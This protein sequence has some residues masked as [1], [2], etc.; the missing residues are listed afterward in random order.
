MGGPQ[1]FMNTLTDLAIEAA[2]DYT[3]T[4]QEA[5]QAVSSGHGVAFS[6]SGGAGHP[7]SEGHYFVAQGYDPSTGLFDF[8]ETA[9]P[10]PNDPNAQHA[11]R[12]GSR[13][14]TYEQVVAMAGPV[15]ALITL[16]GGVP[17]VAGR[18]SDAIAGVGQDAQAAAPLVSDLGT[19]AG[20][21]STTVQRQFDLMATGAQSTVEEMGDTI[22]T[23]VTDINGDTVQTFTDLHGNVLNQVA[24][25][26]DGT[27]I[28][29]SDMGTS[30]SSIVD[31]TNQTIT[32]KMTD[33]SGN[34]ITTVSTMAG[35]VISQTATMASTAGANIDSVSTAAGNAKGP[36]D[37]LAAT[38]DNPQT[39]NAQAADAAAEAA[40]QYQAALDDVAKAAD[41]ADSQLSGLFSSTF[42]F[43]FGSGN[44]DDHKRARGGPVGPGTW[45]VGEKGPEILNLGAGLYGSVTTNED[46][47]RLLSGGGGRDGGID[48]DRL[49]Q[50]VAKAV[51][52]TRPVVM[53]SSINEQVSRV[54]A[55]LSQQ[56]RDAENLRGVR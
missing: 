42:D 49:A 13:Y 16:L 35:T 27:V 14:M 6:T 52:V 43:T 25:M 21:T 33:A 34:V 30:L 53:V 54:K 45:L 44:G 18:A 24:A 19:A 51:A 40:R 9:G 20:T 23:T 3:P 10:D 2:A 47:R 37:A 48:Y 4:Q 1:A 41:N 36:L 32:T 12:G 7:L 28:K 39:G 50:T 29:L 55:E 31:E 46:T 11:L 5:A 17:Q 26:A 22:K 56:Q 8:G 15:Q 38:F